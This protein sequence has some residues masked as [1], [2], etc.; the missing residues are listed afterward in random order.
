MSVL[1]TNTL[2]DRLQTTTQKID[3][4][5]S[6]IEINTIMENLIS[7]LMEAEFASV[8]FYDAKNMLLL[9]ERDKSAVR[10]ISISEKK[11]ILYKCFMTKKY[12]IY[13]YLT[14]EKEYRA[15]VDNPDKIQIKSAI[16]FPLLDNDS[17]V[18]IITVYS[19]VKKI[20]LFSEDD[21]ELLE[22]ISPY[23]INIIYK[24]H[25]QAKPLKDENCR[26][27]EGSKRAEFEAVKKVE[28]M[29][30]LREETESS[31]ETLSFMS[32]TI[33][34]IRTPANTLYGFL[35]ILEDKIEDPRLKQYLL[36]AKESAGLINE[37]TNSI[38]DRISFQ[39]ERK[40][41]QKEAIESVRFFSGIADMFSSNMYAKGLNY[42]V[43]IDPLIPKSIITEPL[44]LKRIL[45]NLINNAH[46]FT[47]TKNS[48]DFSVRYN[49]KDKTLSFSVKDTGIG[50]VKEKQEEIFKAFKQG[51]DTTVL[52]YGGTGLGLAIS[53]NYV[54]DLGGCFKL[55]SEPD[56][57]SEFSFE[58]PIES[59]DTTS[60][61]EVG[62]NK[63]LLIAILMDISNK[64]SAN[65][66]ARYLIRMGIQKS[67]I[68]PVSS[69]SDYPKGMTHLIT[70][71][72][73]TNASVLAGAIANNV[74]C[75]VVEE[76][77]FSVTK[78]DFHKNCEVM[79][80]YSSC[81]YDLYYFISVENIPKILIVD[82]DKISVSLI[83][84]LLEGEF[85]KII[86]CKNGEEALN[87]LMNAQKSKTPFS[88]VYLDNQIPGISG[89]EL[90]KKFREYEKKKQLK[91]I[92]AVS[93]SGEAPKKE[94]DKKLF[95][96]YA[97]KPFK[98][99]DIRDALSKLKEN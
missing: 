85:C 67:Q 57:G 73:K 35:E 55:T 56:K 10:E 7:S 81:A 37:L 43:F 54:K 9:R 80:Q 11:G 18:G 1:Q 6:N 38:L 82:D 68:V 3:I 97:S 89:K 42:N 17:L 63:G 16:M 36:N 76:S 19:S 39:R 99:E 29:H 2:E 8:W 84:T 12:G 21:L 31:D 20:K 98:K 33:H 52:N 61:F 93:I 32:N 50:I 30:R 95:N 25:P 15:S 41:S 34:D 49:K 75:L 40:E 77:L 70:F 28:E 26:R 90:I 22:A 45:M 14:S 69:P 71:Q 48:V 79:S 78:D 58:I 65:N 83:K 96:M 13:N 4:T 53:S 66:I 87:L 23:I 5:Q 51:E 88:L 64:P 94:E 74:K 60:S 72:K 24:I 27:Q 44:K 92:Y 62:S 86:S 59:T 91:P 47:S 46:K